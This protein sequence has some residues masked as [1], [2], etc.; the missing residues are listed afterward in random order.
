MNNN[1]LPMVHGMILDMDKS[2]AASPIR[3][4]RR[5]DSAA[6]TLKITLTCGGAPFALP[7]GAQVTVYVRRADGTSLWAS[8]ETEGKNCVSHTF[9][10]SELSVPGKTLCELYIVTETASVTSPKF[11]LYVEDILRNDAAITASD[12]FPVLAELVAK[13]QKT[14]ED[15]LSKAV[16]TV[17][18]APTS[19]TE[20]AVGDIVANKED[21]A[22]YRCTKAENGRYGWELVN[23]I[24]YI[25]VYKPLLPGQSNTY[26]A[27]ELEGLCA[28]SRN[29]LVF[30]KYHPSANTQ[31]FTYLPA[32][33]SII[34][35]VL[36]VSATANTAASRERVVVTYSCTGKTGNV[37]VN[38]EYATPEKLSDENYYKYAPPTVEAVDKM[39][40]GKQD[41]QITDSGNYF[42]QKTVEGAL[43][44]LGEALA[45]SQSSLDAVLAMIGG[46]T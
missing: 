4:Y 9:A 10:A 17:E 30:I 21:A 14:A 43:Q 5:D 35:S 6:H 42:T 37:S 7:E 33:Y 16:L 23:K 39:L 3:L 44:E 46:G 11:T 2:Y 18:T 1:T 45:G 13:T 26:V 20:G 24:H 25:T 41:S 19:S 40:E 38:K 36:T 29:A 15:L 28:Q 32:S 22:L 34:N 12:E 27:S 8:C 31:N